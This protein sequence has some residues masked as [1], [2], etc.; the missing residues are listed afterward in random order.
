MVIIMEHDE[1]MLMSGFGDRPG[2]PSFYPQWTMDIQTAGAAWLE[3]QPIWLYIKEE[4]FSIHL[5]FLA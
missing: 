3:Q 2:V 5:C 4:L 1:E